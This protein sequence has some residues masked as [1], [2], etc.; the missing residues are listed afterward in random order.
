M[1]LWLY[2]TDIFAPDAKIIHASNDST[3]TEEKQGTHYWG[4]VKDHL[5]DS[6]A[7]ISFLDNEINGLI[8]LDDH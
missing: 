6:I 5:E 8:E 2:Q 3:T 4:I 1:E 7:A